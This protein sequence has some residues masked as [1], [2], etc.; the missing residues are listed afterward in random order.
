MLF[1]PIENSIFVENHITRTSDICELAFICLHFLSFLRSS[2]GT[3][4]I[5]TNVNV[6]G[7]LLPCWL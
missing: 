1:L 5:S 4:G 6:I 2:Y 3:V 7:G